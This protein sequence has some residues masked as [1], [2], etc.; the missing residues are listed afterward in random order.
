LN[1]KHLLG[2]HVELHVLVNTII[3]KRNGITNIGWV[4]HPETKRYENHL[5]MLHDRHEQQVQEMNR[6]GYNHKSPLLPVDYTLED[7]TYSNE[8]YQEDITILASRQEIK[9]Y[10]KCSSKIYSIFLNNTRQ[11]INIYG[12]ELEQKRQTNAHAKNCAC[13]LVS[14]V[15]FYVIGVVFTLEEVL[16]VFE[17]DV[18]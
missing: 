10:G 3:N 11:C 9:D 8:E 4:N 17:K 7:F 5:G 15:Q 6:R 2:E 14:L 1:R 16:Q 13:Y 12:N 18:S